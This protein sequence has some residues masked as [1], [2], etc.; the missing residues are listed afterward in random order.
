MSISLTR[1]NENYFPQEIKKIIQG[2]KVLNL[3]KIHDKLIDSA[4]RKQFRTWVKEHEDFVAKSPVLRQMVDAAYRIE[5]DTSLC[6]DPKPISFKINQ[7]QLIAYA[8]NDYSKETFEGVDNIHDRVERDP[9]KL[10][11]ILKASPEEMFLNLSTIID[12]IEIGFLPEEQCIEILCTHFKQSIPFLEKLPYHNLLKVLAIQNK[13]GNLPLHDVSN[14][15]EAIPL[16]KALPVDVKVKILSIKNYIGQTLLHCCEIFEE[17]IPILEELPY[18]ELLNIFAL[19]DNRGDTP[20]CSVHVFYRAI[21]F[22]ESLLEKSPDIVLNILFTQDILA[23]HF[24]LQESMPILQKLFEQVPEKTLK[25][26]LKKNDL[27]PL[28][29]KVLVHKWGRPL[30][31]TLAEHHQDQLIQLLSSKDRRGSAF[32]RFRKSFS[33]TIPYLEKLMEWSKERT[34]QLL[35]ANDVDGYTP[36]HVPENFKV[37]QHLI[38]KHQIDVNVFLDVNGL[39]PIDHVNYGF[40]KSWM[41][42]PKYDKEEQAF[43]LSADEYAKRAVELDQEYQEQITQ[44]KADINVLWNAVNIEA[45]KQSSES[46]IEERKLVDHYFVIGEKKYTSEEIFNELQEVLKLMEGKTAWL[47]TPRADNLAALYTF[48][49]SQL[50]DFEKIAEKLKE[51]ND[52]YQTAGSITSILYPRVTQGLCATAY[53]RAIKQQRIVLEEK[54][55][56]LTLDGMLDNAIINAFENIIMENIVQKEFGGN[57]HAETHFKYAAGLEALPEVEA[58]QPV[59]LEK[60]QKMIF[61]EMTLSKVIEKFLQQDIS[62][63]TAFEWLK[64]NTPSDFGPEYHLCINEMTEGE[65]KLFKACEQQLEFL[66]MEKRA[67]IVEFFR[68]FREVSITPLLEHCQ[69]GEQTDMLKA[70]FQ[71]YPQID[72]TKLS[73]EIKGISEN[74]IDDFIGA[75]QEEGV[76]LSQQYANAELSKKEYMTKRRELNQAM[77]EIHDQVL[78]VLRFQKALESF[79]LS[80][81][82]KLLIL[83]VKA[84]FESGI[85]D[86]V[87]IPAK[88]AMEFSFSPREFSLPSQAIENTRRNAY[89]AQFAG[90]RAALGALLTKGIFE[91]KQK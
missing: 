65:D 86:I 36:I 6:K 10:M 29:H 62:Q 47:G 30:M 50:N 53:K 81:N 24:V 66:P 49:K 79:E 43:I 41:T 76:K 58:H 63:E 8:V 56:S 16:L 87:K 48:Y 88:Y 19:R 13:H 7:V 37:I 4:I 68:Y 15:K 84:F 27:F 71:R 91:K 39:N 23:R 67:K 46:D 70:I 61:Y 14:L 73:V 12:Y 59:S 74:Q 11:N 20:L 60:A 28:M 57:V 64:M 83:H 72:Q 54:P 32:L 40:S 89:N 25:F 33:M 22:L 9:I 80:S 17:V 35:S 5:M 21:P 18:E 52:V 77:T 69:S 2:N 78:A 3:D 55:G 1:T 75:L 42:K 31:S 82:E 90:S 51:K 45:Q 44:L 26:M 34:I 85:E 38:Q